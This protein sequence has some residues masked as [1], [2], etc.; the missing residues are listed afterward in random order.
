MARAQGASVAPLAPAKEA[1]GRCQAAS[2]LLLGPRKT[3]P[4][5][6]G[7][8]LPRRP[9]AASK[10]GTGPRMPWLWRCTLQSDAEKR[11]LLSA[12]K[13]ATT[14]HFPL[15]CLQRN[16]GEATGRVLSPQHCCLPGGGGAEPCSRLPVTSGTGVGQGQGHFTGTRG[17]RSL[18]LPPQRS[19]RAAPGGWAGGLRLLWVCTGPAWLPSLKHTHAH[20]HTR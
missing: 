16:R 20:T 4:Q 5:V 18:Q 11:K 14:L 7:R 1:T 19:S 17:H 15:P 6:R 10:R 3:K 9:G 13:D 2:A 12:A 8:L